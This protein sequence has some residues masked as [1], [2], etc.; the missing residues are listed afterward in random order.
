MTKEEDALQRIKGDFDRTVKPALVETYSFE[1]VYRLFLILCSTKPTLISSLSKEELDGLEPFFLQG[2]EACISALSDK[3]GLFMDDSLQ[4]RYASLA[5]TTLLHYLKGGMEPDS[6]ALAKQ[7]A[8][9]LEKRLYS[10]GVLEP[11]IRPM[12]VF[13]E[14]RA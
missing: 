11:D 5:T 1:Y 13:V 7:V 9:A 10:D 4:Q 14:P 8:K 3:K 2:M 12:R 6:A